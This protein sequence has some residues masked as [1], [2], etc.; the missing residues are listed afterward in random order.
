VRPFSI[1][2]RIS[3]MRRILRVIVGEALLVVFMVL[4]SALKR[5]H[6]ENY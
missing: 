3:G 2:K 4:A 6:D 1:G 5:W